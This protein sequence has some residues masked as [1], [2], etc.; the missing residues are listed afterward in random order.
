MMSRW[1]PDFYYYFDAMLGAARSVPDIIQKCFEWDRPG[2][3]PG[4]FDI[5]EYGAAGMELSRS[6]SIDI[7]K[8]GGSGA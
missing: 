7:R 6:Q 5:Y 4:Q 8:R 2:D 3:W 1:Q